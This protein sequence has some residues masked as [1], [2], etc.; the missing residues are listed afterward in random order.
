[1]ASNN[2]IF[3]FRDILGKS[4]WAKQ[5]IE[6]PKPRVS[7]APPAT[8]DGAAIVS[9][10]GY[11]GTYLDLD[12]ASRNESTLIE[13]YRDIAQYPDCDSAIEDIVTEAIVATDDDVP[14]TINTDA[15]ELP[16]SIREKI[17]AE[18]KN[19]CKLMDFNTR[20]HDIFR[21]W[22]VDGRIYY[23]KIVDE[24]HPKQGIKELR[25]LDPRK[26]RKV[27]T[28]DQQVTTDGN[29]TY[30]TK[31]EFYVYSDAGITTATGQTRSM[32]QMTLPGA[33]QIA[34]ES[35][36]CATSGILDLDKNLVLGYLHKAIRPVNHLR[37]MEDA[38][39]IFRSTR[40]PER[41]IFYVDVSG[42]NK[43]KAESYLKDLMNKYRN[44]VVYDAATGE[45]KDNKKH[46]TMLEDFWMPR[47]N[48]GK[49]TEI[50][51]LPGLQ[52]T[53]AI[54]DVNFFQK[55]LSQ[56]LNVPL[57]RMQGDSGFGFGRVAEITRDELKFSKFVNRLRKRFSELFH[58]LL[59]TQL[60]LKGIITIDDW[61]VIKDQIQYRFLSDTSMSEMRA[62]ED[63]R[64]KADLVSQL[65][66]AKIIGT[67]FSKEYVMKEIFKMS[68][69]TIE[70][71]QARI[72][73]EMEISIQRMAQQQQLQVQLGLEPQQ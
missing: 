64:N 9:E 47:T 55:K 45:V 72:D 49:G 25:Y 40:A 48:T 60:I 69:D 13:R 53:G 35:V 14:V 2:S 11:Y 68:D 73:Q 27:R 33:I 62:I 42:L 34:P 52:N 46:M 26:T 43:V 41:R 24:D 71:E 63:L 20:G 7:F 29:I 21:R 31:Q 15:I 50:S 3:N 65:E 39:V 17:D 23:H 4:F 58:D 70:E 54:D 51:T 6:S 37:M 22:Y 1:M 19:V 18:F 56:S 38:L 59:K 67:Y 57:S 16:K 5:N 10:A 8:D 30:E 44:K 66:Q 36:A 61:E 28:V 12:G 32:S